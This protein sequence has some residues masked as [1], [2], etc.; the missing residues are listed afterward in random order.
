[1]HS[2]NQL[3]SFDQLNYSSIYLLGD[4]TMRRGDEIGF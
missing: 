4:N 2:S 3:E 1:M